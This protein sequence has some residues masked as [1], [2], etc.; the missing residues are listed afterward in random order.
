MSFFHARTLRFVIAVATSTLP[1]CGP[2]AIGLEGE[3]GTIEVT[4]AR[5][6]IHPVEI[7]GQLNEAPVRGARV[8]VRTGS[9][10]L[11]RRVASDAAG[12][13]RMQVP[14]GRWTLVVET[15]P[16]ALEI[17]AGQTIDVVASEVTVTRF[18]CDTGIR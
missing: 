7:E 4:V 10:A 1:A 15:C 3:S 14:A 12:I 18:T 11:I 13:A 6:P 2:T 9:G 8:T 17:P 16:G 5:S